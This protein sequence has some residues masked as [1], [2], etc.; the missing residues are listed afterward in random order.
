MRRMEPNPYEAPPPDIEHQ[1]RHVSPIGVRA[2]LAAV[3]LFLGSTVS[4]G[5]AGYLAAYLVATSMSRDA[6]ARYGDTV[7][8]SILAAGI[9][10]GLAC[11]FLL[12]ARTVLSKLW[13]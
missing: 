11:G 4:G 8:S 5:V 2:T 3:V 12:A 6:L 9:L 13:R 1:S 10:I 7:A